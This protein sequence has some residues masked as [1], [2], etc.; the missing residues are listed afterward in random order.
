MKDCKGEQCSDWDHVNHSPECIAEHER[1]YK[2]V[3][4]VPDC[5]DRA[6]RLGRVFDNCR[7]YNDCKNV[8]PICCDN[9]VKDK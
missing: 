4:I 7:F 5:F 9:P 1:A 8:K 6:E 2:G 3:A